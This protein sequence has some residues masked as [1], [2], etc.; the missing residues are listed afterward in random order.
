MHSTI[1]GV[2]LRPSLG[3]NQPPT[4]RLVHGRTG[5]ND[6]RKDVENL[7]CFYHL[8]PDETS[9]ALHLEEGATDLLA[10]TLT[11]TAEPSKVAETSLLPAAPF[12]LSRQALHDFEPPFLT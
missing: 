3:K 7:H 4:K 9:Q 11:K 1:S 12:L 8:V 6:D 5:P 2:S 10:K